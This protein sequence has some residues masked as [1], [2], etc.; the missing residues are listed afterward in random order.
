MRAVY[1]DRGRRIVCVVGGGGAGGE[2]GLLMCDQRTELTHQEVEEVA[3]R[4]AQR[5]GDEG[6]GA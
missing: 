1:A 4:H 5:G 2:R 6:A 3:D